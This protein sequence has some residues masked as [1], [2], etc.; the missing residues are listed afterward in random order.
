MCYTYK[1]IVRYHI[2]FI[3]KTWNLEERATR[4][5]ESWHGKEA[6]DIRNRWRTTEKFST[7]EDAE[8]EMWIQRDKHNGSKAYRVLDDN[9]DVISQTHPFMIWELE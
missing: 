9:D 3:M 2:W 6:F 7:Y 8:Y 5:Y 1:T 4:L